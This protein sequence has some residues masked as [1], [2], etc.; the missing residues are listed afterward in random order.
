MGSSGKAVSTMPSKSLGSSLAGAAS[1]ALAAG[2]AAAR[3][4]ASAAQLCA[5]GPP[6]PSPSRGG[7]AEAI[8]TRS[9]ALPPHFGASARDELAAPPR[10]GN[11]NICG[12][13]SCARSLGGATLFSG[14]PGGGWRACFPHPLLSAEFASLPPRLGN[15]AAPLWSRASALHGG[16]KDCSSPPIAVLPPSEGYCSASTLESSPWSPRLLSSARRATH[17]LT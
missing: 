14:I 3:S 17:R 2:A 8:A 4:R 7:R 9:R 15:C 1:P 6:A 13:G 12:A 5:P 10:A 16:C 11:S